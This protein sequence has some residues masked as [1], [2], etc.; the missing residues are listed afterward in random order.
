MTCALTLACCT[1]LVVS[2]HE[3]LK[4]NSHSSQRFIHHGSGA[5][6]VC[7]L[8]ELNRLEGTCDTRF[9]CLFASLF[10]LSGVPKL[11]N[12]LFSV[13]PQ[14]QPDSAGRL[15]RTARDMQ[16]PGGFV[17]EVCRDTLPAEIIEKAR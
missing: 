6:S 4:R 16:F 15:A 12:F 7:E 5:D 14:F 10:D 3:S 8:N 11:L 2:S 9:T 17:D 13:L 1:S